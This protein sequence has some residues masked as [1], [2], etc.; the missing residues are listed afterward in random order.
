MDF[1]TID[2]VFSK[3]FYLSIIL[4]LKSRKIIRY[5]Q[6]NNPCR[7]FIKQRIEL[8][9]E[10]FEDHKITLI[11]DNAPQFTSTDYSW[12]GIKGV[13]I[14]S[15]APNMNAYAERLNGS[16]RR[17]AI[18]HF[19]LIFQKIIREYVN[20]HNHQRPHQGPGRIP[21]PQQQIAYGKTGK[22][23]VLRGLH[24]TYY[25]SSARKLI[26]PIGQDYFQFY[27]LRLLLFFHY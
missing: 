15:Y 2:T 26:K 21:D 5:D 1:I 11:F 19:L 6:T 3:R 22:E 24:N 14:C 12:F 7:E 25:R 23:P 13:K 9:S 16:V 4:E 8:F 27:L 20:Y 17:E 18:D 10:N